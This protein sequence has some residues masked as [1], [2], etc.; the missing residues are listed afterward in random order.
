MSPRAFTEQTRF[1]GD[2]E[3]AELTTAA[4][5][6]SLSQSCVESNAGSSMGG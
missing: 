5:A 1:I 3:A 2:I 6:V 4:A